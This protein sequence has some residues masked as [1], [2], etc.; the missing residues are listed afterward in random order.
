MA[1]PK[2]KRMYELMRE[3]HA[4]LFA[5]FAPIHDAFAKNKTNE[6]AFHSVGRDV[7]DVIRDWERRLCAGMERGMHG[8]YSNKVAEKFWGEVKKEFPLIE[9]VG[10]RSR[11]KT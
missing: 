11:F 5:S 9:L 2:F 7:T 3:Q 8:Q 6:E 1:A 10:V 4:S